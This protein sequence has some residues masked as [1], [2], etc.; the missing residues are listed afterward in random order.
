M[1]QTQNMSSWKGIKPKEQPGYM[2]TKQS[3]DTRASSG[4]ETV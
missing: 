4:T 1:Q 3:R 2:A